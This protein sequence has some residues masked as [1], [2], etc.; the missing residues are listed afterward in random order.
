M[1]NHVLPIYKVQRKEIQYSVLAASTE[2]LKTEDLVHSLEEKLDLFSPKMCIPFLL[3]MSLTKP[4]IPK[5][6]K[7]HFK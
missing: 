1:N 5:V 6:M 7:T 2:S 4:D 3:Q